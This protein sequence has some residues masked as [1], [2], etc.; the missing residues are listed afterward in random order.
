MISSLMPC[1]IARVALCST[2]E[3]GANRCSKKSRSVGF[4]GMTERGSSSSDFASGGRSGAS[5]RCIISCSSASARSFTP[6]IPAPLT[7]AAAFRKSLRSMSF[8]SWR[9][10]E[11][12]IRSSGGASGEPCWPSI[13][14]LLPASPITAGRSVGT[15]PL[16]VPA[17]GAQRRREARFRP[18]R[19]RRRGLRR[20]A[21]SRLPARAGPAFGPE[22]P[23]P[24]GQRLPRPDHPHGG[25]APAVPALGLSGGEGGPRRW[26]AAGSQLRPR[27]G[28]G[29]PF[30]G[31]RL[32]G[33]R[34][35]DRRRSAPGAGGGGRLRRGRARHRPACSSGAAWR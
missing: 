15:S 21:G 32:A 17:P 24:G 1:F 20:P 13:E 28:R 30:L 34:G 9:T 8:A 10:G 5:S 22:L 4:A 11:L 29:D 25:R 35:T 12:P 14:N 26:A 2:W 18:R 7:V 19:R 3:A 33:R 23:P 31:Q 16:A 27:R 6:T